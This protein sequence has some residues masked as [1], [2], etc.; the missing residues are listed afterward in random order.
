MS[1]T[2]V[3][4]YVKPQK[5]TKQFRSHTV[6]DDVKFYE[7]TSGL[8][9]KKRTQRITEILASLRKLKFSIL[10]VYLDHEDLKEFLILAEMM[11]MTG[12]KY[13]WILPKRNIPKTIPLPTNILMVQL[14]NFTNFQNILSDAADLV[15][16]GLESYFHQHKKDE[17]PYKNCLDT[18]YSSF[19]EV[20]Y[21]LTIFT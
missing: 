18:R 14:N 20:F 10:A 21:R 1:P 6:G 13:K 8:S 9:S 4:C 7:L 19:G 12:S 17:I 11:Q 3:V 16:Y 2:A 15:K 5:E